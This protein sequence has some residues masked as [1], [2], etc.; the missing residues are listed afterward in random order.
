MSAQTL[1]ELT[2]TII[3]SSSITQKKKNQ[4]QSAKEYAQD[5]MEDKSDT[6]ED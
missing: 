2:K 5:M 1:Q 4:N 3:I 6:T